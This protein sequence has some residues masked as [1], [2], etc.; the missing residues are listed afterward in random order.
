MPVISP[1]SSRD[2]PWRWKR[3]RVI[4]GEEWSPPVEEEMEAATVTLV[5]VLQVPLLGQ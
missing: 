5:A 2:H 3:V 1:A 4:S